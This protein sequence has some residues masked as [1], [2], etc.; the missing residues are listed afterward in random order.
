[1]TSL[2]PGPIW[3]VGRKQQLRIMNDILANH[4]LRYETGEV[5]KI[6]VRQLGIAKVVIVRKGKP[7]NVPT[8]QGKRTSYY[9][10]RFQGILPIREVPRVSRERRIMNDL[11]FIVMSGWAVA[12]FVGSLVALIVW[13]ILKALGKLIMRGFKRYGW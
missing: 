10:N 8:L 5:I 11:L 1:M 12:A 13:S 9:I 2:T 7:Q 6:N 4:P 3:I